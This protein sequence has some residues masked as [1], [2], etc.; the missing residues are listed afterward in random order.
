MYAINSTQ[1][2][3]RSINSVEDLLEGE[4]FSVGQPALTTVD[5]DYKQLRAAEYP[6]FTE[7]PKP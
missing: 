2:G 7:Y 3:W 5:L 4:T 6:P 1:N